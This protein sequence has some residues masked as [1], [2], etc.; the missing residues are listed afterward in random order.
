M[1]LRSHLEVDSSGGVYVGLQL[2]TWPSRSAVAMQ[3]L[4]A[5]YWA[6]GTSSALGVA[7]DACKGPLQRLPWCAAFVAHYSMVGRISPD[8]CIRGRQGMKVAPME[9]MHKAP[10][11]PNV[12]TSAK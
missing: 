1:L 9:D 12:P 11:L 2:P 4:A 8:A 7:L 10:G 3:G 6:R 5:S